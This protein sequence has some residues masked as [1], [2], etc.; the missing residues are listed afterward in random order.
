MKKYPSI[1]EILEAGVLAVKADPKEQDTFEIRLKR[2]KKECYSK[3]NRKN[4]LIS[5]LRDAIWA[6][7]NP[8]EP[9]QNVHEYSDAMVVVHSLLTKRVLVDRIRKIKKRRK[10]AKAK[11]K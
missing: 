7:A 1:K 6:A 11:L 10:E 5:R 9:D 8:N 4:T 2:A 3:K